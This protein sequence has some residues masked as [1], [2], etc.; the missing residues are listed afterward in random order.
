MSNIARTIC[1]HLVGLIFVF[2]GFVKAIDPLGSCYK[3][4]EYFN[5]F[6]LPFAEPA[7]LP[8][9]VLLAVAELAIGLCLIVG[10]RMRVTAWALLL[11]MTFFTLLTLCLAVFNPVSDC[12]CFGDAVKLTNWQTFF[13]NLALLAP[14]L[15]IFGYRRRYAGVAGAVQEWLYVLLFVAA[16]AALSAYCYRHLPLLDFLPFHIGQHIPSA[17]ATPEGAPRDEYRTVLT[18]EKDGKRQEFADVDAP[19][20]DSAW[21]FVRSQSTLVQRGYT[22]PIHDFALTGSDGDDVTDSVLSAEYALLLVA[23][24]LEKADH[25][26]RWDSLQQLAAAA[27]G[28]GYTFLCLTTS[29]PDGIGAFA[30]RHELDFGFANADEVALK[31]MV[32]A[33]PG[34]VLLHRGTVIGKWSHSDVPP[35]SAIAEGHLLAGSLNALR[36]AGERGVACGFALGLLAVALL[37]RRRRK[38]EGKE[39]RL[40]RQRLQRGHA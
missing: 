19:W 21:R 34:L 29:S 30:Q 36:Q 4:V 2:S 13:K 18:Y 11:F 7:A 17:I 14:T 10:I 24:K 39:R 3:F 32:R 9:G 26:V 25:A 35:A 1:R 31:S 37:L 38:E 16:G 20:Q 6:G 40:P 33:S 15:L 5:G 28:R 22:P 23:T 12:G 8:L 27:R